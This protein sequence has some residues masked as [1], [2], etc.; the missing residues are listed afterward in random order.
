VENRAAGR[1][2]NRFGPLQ[3]Q[4][5]TAT[6]Y[7]KSYTSYRVGAY[8]DTASLGN[9]GHPMLAA[10]KR[11]KSSLE[12]N[13]P[14]NLYYGLDLKC[15]PKAQ[16]A[17][18]LTPRKAVLKGGRD[19]ERWVPSGRSSGHWGHALKGNCVMLGSSFFFPLLPSHEV[20]FVLP[21]AQL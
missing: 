2:S 17:K 5:Q 19:F 13:L 11:S 21:Q 3:I 20:S 1:R 7:G 18:G 15:S 4:Q 6:G 10:E 12:K 16:C 9:W 14:Q 8:P